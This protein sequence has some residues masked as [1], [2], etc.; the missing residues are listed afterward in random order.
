MM[1]SVFSKANDDEKLE[2][3]DLIPSHLSDDAEKLLEGVK[4]KRQ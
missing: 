4:N 2:L 3:I 1:M